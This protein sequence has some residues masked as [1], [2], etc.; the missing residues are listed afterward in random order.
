MKWIDAF[1]KL[2]WSNK[3]PSIKKQNFVIIIIMY[4]CFHLY[5]YNFIHAMHE[6]SV[7]LDT[8]HI[9][10]SLLLFS[11]YFLCF[12]PFILFPFPSSLHP[13]PSSL[14]PPLLL[15]LFV[16]SSLHTHTHRAGVQSTWKSALFSISLKYPWQS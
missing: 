16:F 6:F 7:T 10:S 3:K 15:S 9:C 11:F 2:V 5:C 13:F 8:D 14:L 4:Y 12:L 1:L